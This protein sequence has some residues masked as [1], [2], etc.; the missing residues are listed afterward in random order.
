LDNSEKKQFVRKVYND[1]FLFDQ[2]ACSSARLLFW[3][4]GS[5]ENYH[6]AQI[7]F[8]SRMADEAATRNYEIAPHTALAKFAAINRSAI[9]YDLDAVLRE[10]AHLNIVGLKTLADIRDQNIGAG[11]LYA[12]HI[13]R[14]DEIA[15]F[16][17]RKDQTLSY[18]GF[19]K[20]EINA[21][22][23]D[24]VPY[25]L[26][27]IVPVGNALDFDSV[28]DGFELLGNLARYV[29]VMG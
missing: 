11:F 5:D 3:F 29:R 19:D 10:K 14:V 27:R 17:R 12:K 15:Q 4:Q 8:A 6:Q 25:G 16:L 23:K 18:F 9:D 22:A 28:W 24:L 13:N 1:I 26:D 2:M 21:I 7:D 20:A